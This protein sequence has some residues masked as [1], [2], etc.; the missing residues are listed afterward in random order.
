MFPTAVREVVDKGKK[1]VEISGMR[2]KERGTFR[3]F[4]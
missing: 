3:V 1:F 4:V 2:T